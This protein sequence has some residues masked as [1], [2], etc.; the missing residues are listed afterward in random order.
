[1]HMLRLQ[2]H[3]GRVQ[4]AGLGIIVHVRGVAF[5]C[6]RPYDYPSQCLAGA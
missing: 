6:S 3:S 2:N 1:M 5:V 4:S